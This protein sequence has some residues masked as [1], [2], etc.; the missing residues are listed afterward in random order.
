MVLRK[1]T[2]MSTKDLDLAIQNIK[3][4]REHIELLATL[5][6]Q[7]QRLVNYGR[8]DLHLFYEDLNSTKLLSETEIQ[9]LR[10]EYI[11]QQVSTNLLI[12]TDATN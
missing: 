12:L 2:K 4:D 10:K 5:S 1:Y 9:E 11:L 8:P 3:D 6:P 7:L